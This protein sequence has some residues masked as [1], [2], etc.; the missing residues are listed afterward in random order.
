[1][2]PEKDPKSGMAG[3]GRATW[4]LEHSKASIIPRSIT[5]VSAE[6]SVVVDVGALPALTGR[7]YLVFA[8]PRKG[9]IDEPPEE[10]L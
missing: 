4:K 5:L 2:N 6:E 8:V 3:L 7:G 9:V 10:S 1:M